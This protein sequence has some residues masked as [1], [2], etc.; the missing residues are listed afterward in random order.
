MRTISVW[1]ARSASLLPTGRFLGALLEIVSK[2]HTSG[3]IYTQVG[4]CHQQWTELAPWQLVFLFSVV[5]SWQSLFGVDNGF[6]QPL[7][8][9]VECHLS[10]LQPS[11]HVGQPNDLPIYCFLINAHIPWQTSV[12]WEDRLS[13]CV[14][15]RAQ[16]VVVWLFKFCCF[17]VISSSFVTLLALWFWECRL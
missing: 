16:S 17:V 7:R 5:F 3:S 2:W 9:A 13:A 4:H 10:E 15:C 8:C 12:A 6:R 1:Y 11:E 14:F